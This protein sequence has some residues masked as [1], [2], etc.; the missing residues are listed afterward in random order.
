M[1]NVMR[2]KDGSEEIFLE[3]VGTDEFYAYFQRVIA[4]KLGS[5]AEQVIKALHEESSYNEKRLNSD[6]D[7]YEASLESNTACFQEILELTQKMNILLSE[8]RLNRKKL[9]ELVKQVEKAIKNQI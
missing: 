5:D 3:A 8:T 1:A 9:L 7:A 2:F 6:M 4:E